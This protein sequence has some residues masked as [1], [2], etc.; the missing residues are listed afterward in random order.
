MWSRPAG[1]ASLVISG[2]IRGDSEEYTGDLGTNVT[3]LIA[4]GI[5][6]VAR[7]GAGILANA[8]ALSTVEPIPGELGRVP[9]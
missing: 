4:N 6:E 9:W 8:S 3:K 2:H 1:L 7:I 5:R